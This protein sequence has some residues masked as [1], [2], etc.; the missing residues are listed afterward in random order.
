M[1]LR[2]RKGD[3]Y[4][5]GFI[6][7][8]LFD[9]DKAGRADTFP[10]KGQQVYELRDY[11]RFGTTYIV[12]YAALQRTCRVSSEKW[13]GISQI[14]VPEICLV[15]RTGNGELICLLIVRGKPQTVTLTA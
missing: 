15:P 10:G 12:F 3:G 4:D 5:V 6:S 9:S 1:G 7:D 14:L 13:E 2:A 8:I 11:W